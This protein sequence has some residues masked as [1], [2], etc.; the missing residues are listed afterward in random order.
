MLCIQVSQLASFGTLPLLDPSPKVNIITHKP[1]LRLLSHPN[2][3]RDDSLAHNTSKQA[4]ENLFLNKRRVSL[5]GLAGEEAK[6]VFAPEEPS[7]VFE[8]PK[9]A[10]GGG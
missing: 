9:P 8:C 4:H 1:P 6:D 7:K 3:P 5:G 10:E 2:P